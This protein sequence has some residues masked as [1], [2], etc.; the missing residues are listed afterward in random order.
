MTSNLITFTKCN[1]YTKPGTVIVGNCHWVPI[2]HIGD[3]ILSNGSDKLLLKNLS[4]VTDIHKH[5]LS[6]S[7][8]AQDNNVN[9]EF[10]PTYCYM[11]DLET[12]RII[13]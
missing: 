12:H 3:S 5:L 2:S 8:F 6:I 4:Y 11:K 9:F 13:L 10:C 7:R 1:S